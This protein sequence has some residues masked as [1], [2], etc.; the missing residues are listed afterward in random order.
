M[1]FANHANQAVRYPQT[2]P[3]TMIASAELSQDI[4]IPAQILH[5]RYVPGELR[6]SRPSSPLPL[7]SMRV[8]VSRIRK[9]G[10]IPQ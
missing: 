9:K 3:W 1:E 6:L 7:P 10:Y 2:F 8:G 4:R 5:T